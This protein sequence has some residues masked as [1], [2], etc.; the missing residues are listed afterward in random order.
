MAVPQP[1]LSVHREAQA[2]HDV[3]VTPSASPDADSHRPGLAAASDALR[4]Y[5]NSGPS[6]TAA[7]LNAAD[8]QGR[9]VPTLSTAAAWGPVNAESGGSAEPPPSTPEAA[10]YEAAR[11]AVGNAAIVLPFLDLV[12]PAVNV[13][14]N[15]GY[16][17][18]HGD[19][20]SAKQELQAAG[21]STMFALGATLFPWAKGGGKAGKSGKSG[22]RITLTHESEREIHTVLL[23]GGSYAESFQLG[24]IR[25][26]RE[27]F[28][29]QS[30]FPI[31][32]AVVLESKSNPVRRSAISA[33]FGDSITDPTVLNFLKDE[34]IL[35]AALGRTDPASFRLLPIRLLRVGLEQTEHSVDRVAAA[36]MLLQLLPSSGHRVRQ[37]LAEVAADIRLD[38]L[39]YYEKHYRI[40]GATRAES[41]VMDQIRALYFP[42]AQ[43]AQQRMHVEPSRAVDTP[44]LQTNIFAWHNRGILE[45]RAQADTLA[46][47]DFDGTL[48]PIVAH[49]D[50]AAMRPRTAQLLCRVKERFPVGV[51]SGRALGDLRPRLGNVQVDHLIG[52]HGM[53]R[54]GLDITPFI[55]TIAETNAQLNRL[56][57]HAPEKDKI[58]LENKGPSLTLH[59][60][61]A[62]DPARVSQWIVDAASQLRG[63][64]IQEGKMV[65]NITPANAPN[66]GDA[67]AHLIE[68]YGYK[69]ILY[70]GDDRTDFDVFERHLPQVVGISVGRG[71]E[72]SAPYF[73]KTQRHIDE[74]LRQLGDLRAHWPA[75]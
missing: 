74:L 57:L 30:Q 18:D 8:P 37:D 43:R 73:L 50:A 32:K 67:V 28:S 15:V 48:A 5:P 40:A 12:D 42:N 14:T 62:T 51:I 59:F 24:K 34:R 16:D 41:D 55:S 11:R 7:L 21:I 23:G 31:L 45:D 38:L 35:K 9:P 19:T 6:L 29:P 64:K 13:L 56:L 46:C 68:Q 3:P 26:L 75:R 4:F 49:R 58:G 63:V 39:R 69:R 10:R 52:N 65:V 72:S 2:R 20:A 61:D 66:K 60:R 22:R 1:E 54:T 44:P 47:F 27:H 17:L 33:L 25:Q 71:I 70:V 53:E 36:T